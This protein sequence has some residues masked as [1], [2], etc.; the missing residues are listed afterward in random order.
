VIMPP[1]AGAA[2][3]AQD[4]TEDTPAAAAAAAA[5]AGA[6]PSGGAGAAVTHSH[7]A[8]RWGRHHCLAQAALAAQAGWRRAPCWWG[9]CH[10][11]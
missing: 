8:A 4:G 2:S 7:T 1:A 6:Q 3:G 9:C 10:W 5:A 11:G